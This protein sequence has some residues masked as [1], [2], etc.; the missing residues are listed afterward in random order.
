[1]ETKLPDAE[2]LPSEE[3]IT[4][5]QPEEPASEGSASE[6]AEPS[7]E[8]ETRTV[9]AIG[10]LHGD[11]YR[12][13]RLLLE[14]NILLPDTDA[15][16]PEANKV[17]LVLIGDYVDW[18]NETLE[19]PREDWVAGA[20]RILELLYSLHQDVVRLTA[21]E[22]GFD[23][24]MYALLGNHDD[25]MLEAHKVFTFIEFEQLESFLGNVGQTPVKRAIHE[26]GLSPTNV[27]RLLKFLNWFVQGG[28]ATIKGF[29]GLAEWKQAM[30]GGLGDFLRRYLRIGVVVNGKLYAHTAP[31]NRDFWRPLEDIVGL[32][33]SSWRQAKESFLWSRRVW[34]YDY[35]T[36]TRTAPFTD[37][38]L[39]DMLGG[40]GVN[41]LVVGH[42]PLTRE[43]RPV[44]AYDG[45]VVNI[46]LHGFPDSA[47]LVEEYIPPES[48]NCAPLREPQTP[49]D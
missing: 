14:N 27:E 32:P 39:D 42:T 15:W 7:A 35:Y 38:E 12:L 2:D 21:A 30:D 43:G 41:G 13:R 10:D 36:G 34:G 46:D 11:Y 49:A 31:D 28:E 5:V 1:M 19:G 17:D 22:P 18:R 45:R 26:L 9:V 33:D 4:A 6:P 37:E 29:E 25:M 20:R 16:N 23:S 8:R 24:Q 44:V 3:Q 40:I 48:G 47:A